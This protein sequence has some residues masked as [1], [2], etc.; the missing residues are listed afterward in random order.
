MEINGFWVVM[1]L[2]V[3]MPV[4]ATQCGDQSANFVESCKKTCAP[5]VVVSADASKKIC[6]CEVP[7]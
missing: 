3:I 4:L 2:C 7:K 1:A 5:R 6:S